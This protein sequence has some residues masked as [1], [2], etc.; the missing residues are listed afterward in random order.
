MLGALPFVAVWQQHGKGAHTTPFGLARTD[1]LI[2]YDLCAIDEIAKLAFPDDQRIRFGC[3]ETVFESEH[4][5]FREQ[6]INNP[7]CVRPVD[8]IL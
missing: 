6:R 5:L 2:D 3:R 1:E 8:Q 4:R 7:K